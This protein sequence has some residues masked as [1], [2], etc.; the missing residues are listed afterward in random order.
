MTAESGDG[1]APKT[2]KELK[3]FLAIINY[4]SEFSPDM[5]NVC[6]LLRKLT[7]TETKWTWNATYQKIL[8]KTKSIIKENA[9]M[10]FL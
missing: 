2:K 4:F 1:D 5:A 6:E 10:N 9:C 8:D 7:S 3:V